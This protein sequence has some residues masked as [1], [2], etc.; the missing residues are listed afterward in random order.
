MNCLTLISFM[1]SNA[2]VG[3]VIAKQDRIPHTPL[4]KPFFSIGA[5]KITR[6]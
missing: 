1:G 6:R 3:A 4:N 5:D 2:V